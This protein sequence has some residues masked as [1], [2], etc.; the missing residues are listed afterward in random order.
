MVALLILPLA[1][2]K[3][4]SVGATNKGTLLVVASFLPQGTVPL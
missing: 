1:N 3:R 2:R 4:L